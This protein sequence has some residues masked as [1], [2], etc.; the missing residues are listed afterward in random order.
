LGG[1]GGCCRVVAGVAG[2]VAGV[3]EN[4]GRAARDAGPAWDMSPLKRLV[5]GSG[6]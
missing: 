4:G 5:P 1:G 3:A 6:P 2:A